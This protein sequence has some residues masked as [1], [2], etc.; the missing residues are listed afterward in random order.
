MELKQKIDNYL[1]ELS[2]LESL[3]VGDKEI[4]YMAHKYLKEIQESIYKDTALTPLIGVYNHITK[5]EKQ[6]KEANDEIAELR[7]YLKEYKDQFGISAAQE[8]RNRQ[9]AID[10]GFMSYLESCELGSFSDDV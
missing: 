5:L 8:K 7:Q 9:M 1:D 3:E 6:L 4:A 2:T 10:D